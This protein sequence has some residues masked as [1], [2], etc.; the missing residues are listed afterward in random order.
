MITK[1]TT[2]PIARKLRLTK[3]FYPVL[4]G[5]GVVFYMFWKEYDPNAF[6]SVHFYWYTPCILLI[7]FILMMCRDLGYII[8][9]R[10]LTNNELTWIKAF[11]VIML[12]EFTSAIMPSAV[13]GTSVAILFVNKEGVKVGKSSA[14]VLATSFLDELYFVIAFP[15]LLL[16]IDIPRLFSIAGSTVNNYANEFLLFAI[17]G[18]VI[19]FIYTL[20]VGYGLFINPRGLKWVLLLIF[21]MPL[22]RKWRY[23]AHVAGTDII[24]CAK[25][26]K[27]KP[28]SFWIKAFLATALSWTARYW[29]A[30]SIIL[31]FF[32]VPHQFIIFA[33]QLVMQTILLVCPTPGG[34]GFAEFIFTRYIGEF[35]PVHSAGVITVMAFLWRIAT[36]Y[37][38]L[39]MGAIIVPR[40]IN[41][42]FKRKSK[43]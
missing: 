43:D 23:G 15:L 40:W 38:Y 6:N 36:Y 25:E 32:L 19:K 26:Y 21:K 11:R 13:G 18:Y 8:R 28:F 33:R 4:I 29:V 1:D 35:I 37:P 34:S 27:M 17:I 39:V 9:I 3:I 22:L 7:A 30:N 12:W 2:I 24:K 41:R 20:I 14:A 16:I 5:L 10:I 31:A 42:K